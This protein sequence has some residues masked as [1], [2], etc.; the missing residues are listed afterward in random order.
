MGTHSLLGHVN[1]PEMMLRA[2]GRGIGYV[3]ERVQVHVG[4]EYEAAVVG[5][6]HRMASRSGAKCVIPDIYPLS[7]TSRHI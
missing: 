3:Y 5:W 6:F 1:V 4:V 2:H 7:Y